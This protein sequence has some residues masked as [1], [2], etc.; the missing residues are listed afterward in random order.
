MSKTK[1]KI[2]KWMNGLEIGTQK[3]EMR[4]LGMESMPFL[5]IVPKL[6]AYYSLINC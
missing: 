2:N 3:N 4:P 1:S 6:I 5:P